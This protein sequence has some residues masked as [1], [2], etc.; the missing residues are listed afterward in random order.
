MKMSLKFSIVVPVYNVANYL[1][2]CLNSLIAQ[3]YPDWEAVCV[4]DGSTDRSGEI[5][6]E[7]AIKDPRIKVI[8]QK[9]GGEGEARNAA[10]AHVIGDVIAFVDSD[11]YLFPRALS[12]GAKVLSD[13]ENV[14]FVKF[15]YIAFRAESELGGVPSGYSVK[16][17]RDISENISLGDFSGT[18]CSRFF[19]KQSIEGLRF[20]KYIV[21]ADGLYLSDV[22]GRAKSYS[23]ISGVLYGYRERATSIM[24]SP[25]SLRKQ[26]D[27]FN[28]NY[29]LIQSF[30]KCGKSVDSS[31]YRQKALGSTEDFIYSISLLPENERAQAWKFWYAELPRLRELDCLPVWNRI[32]IAICCAIRLRCVAWLLCYLPHWLKVK[33]LHR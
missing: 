3:D 17:V 13:N 2:A 10:L 23:E 7:Y 18:L 11:D 16:G 4:D 32:V 12:I 29:D 28:F 33:G 25:K 27:G 14:D 22:M 9:N 6:D 1:P 30:L 8:H 21:G 15:G 19:R 26:M 24:Q 31:L 5:L 20:T